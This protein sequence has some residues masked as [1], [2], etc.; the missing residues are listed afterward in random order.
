MSYENDPTYQS[1][2]RNEAV[3]QG[4]LVVVPI[5]LLESYDLNGFEDVPSQNGRYIVAHSDTGH[6]HVL[7]AHLPGQAA[8]S[9]KRNPKDAD[10]E[11]RA[12]VTVAEGAVGEI[13]HLRD[14]LPHSPLILPSGTWVIARQGR[15]TPEGWKKVTD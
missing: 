14:Y 2:L 6:H 15:P 13:R 1:F 4:D 7:C 5:S 11:L 12:L 10:P 8:P 3:A 9:L